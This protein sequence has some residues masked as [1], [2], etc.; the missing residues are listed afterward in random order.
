MS[1]E[2][3]IDIE[4][5]AEATQAEIDAAAEKSAGDNLEQQFDDSFGF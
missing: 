5:P 3:K 1:D 2:K 4:V